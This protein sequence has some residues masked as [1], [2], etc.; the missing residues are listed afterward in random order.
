MRTGSSDAISTAAP[1]ILRRTPPS[2]AALCRCC[3]RSIHVAPWMSAV[4]FTPCRVMAASRRCPAGVG[5]TRPAMHR[6]TWRSGG[7]GTGRS[8]RATA[9]ITTRQES[10]YAVMVQEPQMHGRQCTTRRIGRMPAARSTLLTS[11]QPERVI[12]GMDRRCGAQMCDA[13]HQLANNFDRL[14]VPEGKIRGETR[15]RTNGR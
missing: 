2:A 15:R 4:G 7:R 12:T 6:V 8:S 13:L 1:P 9:F 14:A 10:A 3:H 11:L 5:F